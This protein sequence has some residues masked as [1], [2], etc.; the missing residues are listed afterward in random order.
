[1]RERFQDFYDDYIEMI[2]QT[3]ANLL[4]SQPTQ[5]NIAG[6]LSTIEEKALGNIEKTGTSPSWACSSR[7]RRHVAGLHFMDSSS[8][9]AEYI[10]LMAAVA[11]GEPVPDRPG[12][13]IGN[14]IQPVVKISA[15]PKTVASMADHIDVDRSALL[16]AE[17]GGGPGEHLIDIVE[18]TIDGG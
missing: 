14:P 4:G 9:A 16:T 5:G 1:M 7:R 10:T 6:G 18:R 17:F 11:R 15:N 3:G 2:E 12:Q 13:R 8:A